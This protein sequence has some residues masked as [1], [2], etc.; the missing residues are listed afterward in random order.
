MLDELTIFEGFTCFMIQ[1]RSGDEGID[2]GVG[3]CSLS[4]VGE[5]DEVDTSL[6]ITFCS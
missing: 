1:Y 5:H 4:S 6:G 3:A 2:S